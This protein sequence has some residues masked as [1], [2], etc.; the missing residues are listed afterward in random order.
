MQVT[1]VAQPAVAAT[2][3]HRRGPQTSYHGYVVVLFSVVPLLTIRSNTLGAFMKRL[4]VLGAVLLTLAA[5]AAAQNKVFDWIRAS[6]ESSQ[7]DP[8]DYHVGRVYRPAPDGGNMH[9]DIQSKLPVTVMLAPNDQW[10][11][12]TQHPGAP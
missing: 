11:A 2:P 3:F 9:I 6:D 12:A 10:E 8:M 5:S 1:P 4:L 7:L